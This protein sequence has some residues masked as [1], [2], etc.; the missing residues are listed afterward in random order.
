MLE[1]WG[2]LGAGPK[3]AFGVGCQANLGRPDFEMGRRWDV[4]TRLEKPVQVLLEVVNGSHEGS[5][6]RWTY[7]SELPGIARE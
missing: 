4:G 5:S 1:K 7:L 3:R 2:F 6:F